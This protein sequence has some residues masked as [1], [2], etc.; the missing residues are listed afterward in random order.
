MLNKYQNTDKDIHQRIFRYVVSG[1][2]VVKQIPK[3]LEN[4]PIIS[5][6]AKSLTS[7][8]ANDQEADAASSKRDFIAKYGIVK[9]ETGETIYWW[10][11]LLDLGFKHE[12]LVWLITEGK[13]IFNI[14]STIIKN[15]RE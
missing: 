7:M 6:V 14:V 13:E 10:K 8:G 12:K 3:T 2:Q 1:M 5:Q 15:S 4:I 9:K 11:I